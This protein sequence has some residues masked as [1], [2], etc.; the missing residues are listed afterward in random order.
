MGIQF[1]GCN[2]SAEVGEVF[3]SS[4]FRMNPLLFLVDDLLDGERILLA[5]EQGMSA[6]SASAIGEKLDKA[7]DEGAYET[8]IA[9]GKHEQLTRR[10]LESLREKLEPLQRKIAAQQ[11]QGFIRGAIERLRGRKRKE[12]PAMWD[13]MPEAPTKERVRW[14]AAFLKTCGGYRISY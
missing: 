10:F 13:E 1:Y 7:L 6:E 5:E 14:L 3:G 11:Q 9:A 8:Y 12:H 2:P 4:Y